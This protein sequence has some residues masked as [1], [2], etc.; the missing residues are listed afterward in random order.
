MSRVLPNPHALLDIRWTDALP[1]LD[2]EFGYLLHVD[3]VLAFVGVLF[4]L[5]DL[6]TSGDLQRMILLHSLS[7]GC[8]VP[9]MGRCQSGIRFLREIS[10]P[11]IQSVL[12]TITLTPV[13]IVSI[14]LLDFERAE[15]GGQT[16]L[17]IDTRLL[18]LNLLLQPL[19]CSSIWC[20]T[21][22]LE[23]LYVPK[24]LH[25]QGISRRS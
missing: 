16:Y 19:Q 23:H 25:Q 2:H 22:C 8:D 14:A 1:E 13:K 10:M 15:V 9:Q 3:D 20:S 17:F 21:I 11:P 24:S 6:C 18:L 12:Y 7:I 5:N 4:I